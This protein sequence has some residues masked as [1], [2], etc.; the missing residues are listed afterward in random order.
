MTTLHDEDRIAQALAVCAELTGTVL[1]PAA[2]DVMLEDL[3]AY[4]V[5]MVLNALN[6]CR[7]ELTGRLTLAA[8]LQRM[9]CGLPTADEAFGLLAE[10]AKNEYLTVVVP[11][12]AQIAMGQGAQSLLDLG[13]KTGA[14]MAFRGAY[15]RMV[16]EMRQR[17][18]MGKWMVSAGLDK[19]QMETAINEAVKQGKLSKPQAMMLLPSD[20]AE[21]R[22]EL[23]TGTILSLENKQKAQENIG[24]ILVTLA[25]KMADR[26]AQFENDM[27]K[28]AAAR[29]A[30]L[31]QLESLRH[32]N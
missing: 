14:R 19:T 15:E 21:T 8:I 24:R 26:D 23:Q 11:E 20:A 30:R 3:S 13:D 6:R 2:F 1:T 28:R 27:A 32:A 16:E 31:A 9:D 10:A 4:N 22:Y 12:I 29:Q 7:R 25:S 18:G 17:G 5:Q